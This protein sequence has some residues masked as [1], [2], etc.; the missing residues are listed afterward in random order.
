MIRAFTRISAGP[1]H[2]PY[3]HIKSRFLVPKPQFRRHDT[4]ARSLEIANGENEGE[5]LQALKPLLYRSGGR[6]SVSP[7]GRGI[8]ADFHFK[9]FRKT[10]EFMCKVASR[11]EIECHHPEWTNI[12]NSTSITWTTHRPQGLTMKDIR[13]A[14]FCDEA[15]GDY[16]VTSRAPIESAISR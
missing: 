10:W 3:V 7:D 9:T 2:F 6:W 1:R 11:C 4:S 12:Y 14:E 5:I 13:M 16:G 15:A 8:Q